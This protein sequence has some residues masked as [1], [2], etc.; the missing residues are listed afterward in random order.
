MKSFIYF[1]ILLNSFYLLNSVI[2]N[3]ELTK[4]ASKL[5]TTFPYSYIAYEDDWY[6]FHLTLTRKIFFKE[7]NTLN[8]TNSVTVINKNN[9]TVKD[10]AEVNFTTVG[11]FFHVRGRFYICPKGKYHVYDL[12]GKGFV[13]PTD[14]KENGDLDFE[15]KCVYHADSRYFIALYAMNGKYALYPVYIDND[16]NKMKYFNKLGD[17]FYDFR[18]KENSH[19]DK[20]DYYLLAI[21]KVSAKISLNT[22][23]VNLQANSKGITSTKL[24]DY[25][26]VYDKVIGTFR[27][28][29]TDYKY[30]FFYITYKDLSNLK[31]GYTTSTLGGD[32]SDYTKVELKE[33][34]I[35]HLEF[36]E[37]LEI[38]EIQFM[39]YNRYMYYKFK[40]P[41]TSTSKYYGIFDI[42]L[43]KVIFNTDEYI[44]YFL[45]H[46]ET[47]MLAITNTEAYVICAMKDGNGNCVDYCSNDNYYLDTEGN[48]CGSSECPSNKIMLVPSGVCISSCDPNYYVIRNNACGL[49]QYFYPNDYPYTLMGSNEC[50]DAKSDKMQEYNSKLKI[51]KCIE[52]YKP[53]G[54]EC[55]LDKD[56]PEN[57]LDCNDTACIKCNTG[58]YLNEGKC[59]E[60]CPNGKSPNSNNECQYCNKQ[61][62]SKFETDSCDCNECKEST[63]LK[64]KDC[65]ECGSS[66]KTCEEEATKCT[67]CQE[68]IRFLEDNK[69]YECGDGNCQ[70]KENN[71]KCTSCKSGFFLNSFYKC[72]SCI[73]NCA[74]CKDSKSCDK[75]KDDFFVNTEGKCAQCPNSCATKK[76]DSCQ[77]ATCK[78]GY[79]MNTDEVCQECNSPC[80]SCEESATKC[81]TCI[82]GYFLSGNNSCEK[83]DDSKCKTCSLNKEHCDSCN[84]GLYLIKENNTCQYCDEH[85]ETCSSGEVDG[86]YNCLSC[87][88]DT[89]SKY[90]YLINDEY[91][92][93]CVENCSDYEREPDNDNPFVCKALEKSNG[94][95]PDNKKKEDGTDYLLWIFIAVISILLIIITICICKKCCGEKGNLEITE[96]ISTEAELNEKEPDSIN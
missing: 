69:C 36:F 12:T 81:T 21:D 7:D 2:P 27:N 16:I 13:K 90:K 71:C 57:C 60:H 14:F 28:I 64:D 4:V 32:W 84:D 20:K 48:K 61:S 30:D 78:E 75:C 88:N 29:K 58:Y 25:Y 95:N 26:D 10:S 9:P 91:N 80:N 50:L 59:Q 56:C 3:W 87:K 74:T 5:T 33:N 11:S 66:C 70:T 72:E 55:V 1:I 23:E 92:Q 83:C 77:C 79:F 82:D 34:G 24:K 52:G 42:K 19:T 54:K 39:F 46:S 51:L 41:G 62:C 18:I 49:C 38:E 43:N 86:N 35:A 89:D 85:C 67:S 22:F 15:L 17:E 45:P 65:Y 76:A 44:Q 37:D 53:S 68:G 6:E 93:T 96:E 63:Y 40:I 73:A 31:S 94:T 8:Y 47:E